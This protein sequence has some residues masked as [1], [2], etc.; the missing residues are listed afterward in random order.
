MNQVD[1]YQFST[2]QPLGHGAFAIVYRGHE[3]SNPENEVAVKVIDGKKIERTK[4]L[5]QKEIKILKSL[6]H[7]NIVRLLSCQTCESH[8]YLI[9]E[10]CNYNDL[11]HFLKV[12]HT[13]SEQLLQPITFQ[14]AAAMKAL[15]DRGIM[16]RDLKPQNILMHADKEL[17]DTKITAQHFI[18]G[19]ICLKLA[20]FGF[21]RILNESQMAATLCGSPMYRV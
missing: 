3:I 6:Q 17:H 19:Q 16:H 11:Q 9:M 4:H 15:A 12:N 5:L 13:L 1:K 7:P 10:Y 2:R 8:I 18:R 14:I 20:D 21:A